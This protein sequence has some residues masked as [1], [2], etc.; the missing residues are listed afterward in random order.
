MSVY[1]I[2]FTVALGLFFLFKV[3]KAILDLSYTTLKVVAVFSVVFL[4]MLMGVFK[5]EE[6]QPNTLAEHSKQKQ[7]IIL[8]ATDRATQP[9]SRVNVKPNAQDQ[10]VTYSK[11]EKTRFINDEII[12][13]SYDDEVVEHPNDNEVIEYFNPNESTGKQVDYTNVFERDI[14]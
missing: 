6:S 11:T 2:L 13:E 5:G 14:N 10:I 1:A 3:G 12:E 8:E 9:Q 4:A 7:E